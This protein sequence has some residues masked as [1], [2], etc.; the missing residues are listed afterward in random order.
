M[1]VFGVERRGGN[2]YFYGEIK[3]IKW[4]VLGVIEGG[5]TVVFEVK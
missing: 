5:K 2:G 3:G 1:L 4:Q